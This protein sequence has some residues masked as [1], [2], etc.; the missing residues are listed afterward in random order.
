M[1][2]RKTQ[3]HRLADFIF[4]L[5][6]LENLRNFKSLS[7]KFGPW[8]RDISVNTGHWWTPWDNFLRCSILLLLG[9]H[10]RYTLSE[11]FPLPLFKLRSTYAVLKSL[12]VFWTVV[13]GQSFILCLLHLL[14]LFCFGSLLPSKENK[15]TLL[16]INCSVQCFAKES[17]HSLICDLEKRQLQLITNQILD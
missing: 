8:C 13:W 7:E 9:R 2:H 5:K 16:Q 12:T 11:R 4:K 17:S 15:N 1:Y 14:S 10:N 6:I 3:T